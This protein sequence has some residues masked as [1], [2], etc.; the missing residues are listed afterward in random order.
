MIDRFR[1]A[2]TPSAS[3]RFLC[4]V[5]RLGLVARPRLVVVLGF[6]ALVVGACQTVGGPGAGGPGAGPDAVVVQ[7]GPISDA[8]AEEAARLL[9]SAR[10]SFEARRYFE[11]IRTADEILSRFPASPS[12]GEAL[13]LE[14]LSHLEVGENTQAEAAAG[15]YLSLLPPGDSRRA[16]MRLLQARAL[17]DRPAERLDRLLRID[18]AASAGVLDGAVPM[19]RTSVDS[20]EAETVQEAVAAVPADGPLVPIVRARLAVTLLEE[21]REEEARTA[22]RSALDAGV[23]GM[24]AEWAEGVLRGEF[25]EGR[26]RV[27]TFSIGAVLPTSGPPALAEYARGV[28][29][30]IEVAVA[31]VLG[32]EFTLSVVVRDDQGD[33]FLGADIVRELE[34]SDGVSAIVGLLLDDVL[35]SAGRARTSPIPLVSPTA[36]SAPEA[37][38]AVYSLEGAD[39]AAAQAMADYGATRAFQ[40]VAMLYPAGSPVARAEADAFERRASAHGMRVVG[41]FEYQPG[42]TFFEPEIM[43]ARDALRGEELR[44][45]GLAEDDTLH[46]EVLE[47][48]ALFMPIPPEDVELVAPQV[49]HFGLDTLAIELLG[50]SGWTDAQT[51]SQVDTRLTTGVVATAPVGSSPEAEG[52]RRFRE[53]YEDHFQRSLVS[54]AP[55]VGYDATLLLLEALRAG[56]VEPG[57]LRAE[58]E[59]L[60]EIHGATGVFTFHEGRIVRKTE[61]VRIEDGAYAPVE[62]PVPAEPERR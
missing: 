10:E 42:V 2:R 30:G 50:T 59:R 1:G 46:T 21:G 38:E 44:A 28:Q 36:R 48:V 49:I 56:H 31:T 17:E 55:A 57:R 18:E 4:L 58:L 60:D 39:P 27:T 32:D 24:E 16:D 15:R 40:R 26:G 7:P 33:P 25:P 20:L 61:V 14:A 37:G 3:G 53:A 54:Q 13:R 23:R 47:P 12:S 43:G 19:V 41:R 8:D 34:E 29:E 62:I 6:V 35:I 22:A 5:A 9:V 52:P 51:L 45:L 11:V